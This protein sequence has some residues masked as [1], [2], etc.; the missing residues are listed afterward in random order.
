MP[1]FGSN[2]KRTVKPTK[3]AVLFAGMINKFN[4]KRVGGGGSN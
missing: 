2:N 4:I 3:A 1:Y